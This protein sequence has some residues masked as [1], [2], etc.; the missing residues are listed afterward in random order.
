MKRVKVSEIIHLLRNGLSIK[1][2]DEENGLPITRIETISDWTINPYKVGYANL[3]LEDCNDWLL[4]KGDILISHINSKKHLGK[5]ALYNGSPN[6]LVH[7]MNLLCL[8]VDNNIA[9]YRYIYLVLKSDI[10][11]N[12]IPSITKDSVNQSSFNISSFQ[13]LQIPLPPLPE[14]KRIAEILDKADELRTKRKEAL[15]Q[16]DSLVQSTFLEMFGDPVTNPKGWEIVKLDNC[17]R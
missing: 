2:S 14:Q 17:M 16:L 11:R 10:F 9:Y 7:G 4:K 5:C 15:A 8:R 12:Q 1:Q 3:K 6:L 13:N